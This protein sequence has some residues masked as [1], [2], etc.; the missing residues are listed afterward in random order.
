M[1]ALHHISAQRLYRGDTNKDIFMYILPC[2]ILEKYLNYY[3][4]KYCKSYK[5][6]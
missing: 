4:R 3:K 5:T 6:A 1:I 2:E